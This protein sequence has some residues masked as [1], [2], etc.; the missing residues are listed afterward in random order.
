MGKQLEK[1]MMK[2][3]NVDN[4]KELHKKLGISDPQP[5]IAL[6]LKEAWESD[7]VR[8]LAMALH[9]EGFSENDVTGMLEG[10]GFGVEVNDIARVRLLNYLRE[11]RIRLT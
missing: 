1:R 6:R 5:S 8:D 11:I 10:K 7:P 9:K 2:E 3:Y 4:V